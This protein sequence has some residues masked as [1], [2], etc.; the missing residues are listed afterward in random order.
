[1]SSLLAILSELTGW[2]YFSL[3][4]ISFYP[5][6]WTNYKIG[7]V[8]GYSAEFSIL[9]LSGFLF[10]FLY[11][12]WGYI[13]PSKISG[14][15]DVQDIAFASHSF[16]LTSLLICQCIYYDAQFLNKLQNWVK[17]FLVTVWTLSI[18]FCTLEIFGVFPG[19]LFNLNACLWLGYVKVS[20]TLMK[21]LPQ[22]YKNYRR[23]ST[24]GW[25]IS[26]IL[27]DLSGGI[28]SFLQTFI[29][30]LES[31]NYGEFN[32]AKVCLGMISILFDGI[33]IV[34]HYFLYC[35]SDEVKRP[36]LPKIRSC[37]SA[38]YDISIQV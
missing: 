31:G 27:L 29:D 11:C 13:D 8:E 7:H 10:Y 28:L 25:N 23:K 1:M 36:L 21:Y 2:C 33:F 5:Q 16:I 12:I 22:A 15:V 37:S 3:W 35:D 30:S 20:I 26:T 6:F 18:V 4:S 24:E 17:V 19:F 9:N 32:A 14:V 34:Q 38:E